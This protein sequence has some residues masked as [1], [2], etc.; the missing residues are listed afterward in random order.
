MKKFSPAPI[1]RQRARFRSVGG[2]LIP[3]PKRV[4][5][6]SMMSA[7]TAW[8]SGD[9]AGWI[10]KGCV[11][12]LTHR[13]SQISIPFLVSPAAAMVCSGII[14]AWD[15]WNWVGTQTR[16]VAEAARLIDYVV[17]TGAGYAGIHG[18]VRRS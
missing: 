5:R 14:P 9:M 17:T 12:E 10:R 3:L 8:A 16:W 6:L 4:S 15:A 18:A 2:D 11:L 1:I 7:F 13:N